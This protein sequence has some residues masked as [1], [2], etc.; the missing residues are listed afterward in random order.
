MR[1]R[2]NSINH[3]RGVLREY[4]IVIAKGVGAFKT[5]IVEEL[6]K[7][8]GNPIKPMMERHV[9][10]IKRFDEQEAEANELI[11]KFIEK[12]ERIARLRTIPGIGNMGS[13]VLVSV[14]DDIHRFKDSKHFAS[15]LGLVPKEHS[16]GEKRRL[17]SITRSGSEICRRYL[18]HGARAVILHTKDDC[19]DS[20]REWA[21]QLKG[22]VGINKATVA[23][24]HRL[25]RIAFSVLKNG[26]NYSHDGK[27]P[28]SPLPNGRVVLP[29]ESDNTSNKATAA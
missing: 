16:S 17:S 18:I 14:V 7:L 29:D 28:K 2:S 11:E 19:G 8:E 5:H 3:V 21:K 12:D 4:G 15:Y 23:L 9:E 26:T 22:R 10:N 25:A 13:V 1:E 6:K 27:N 20:N 24:A